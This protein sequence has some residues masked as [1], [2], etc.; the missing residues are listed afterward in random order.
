MEYNITYRQKDKG[1]QFIISAKI[2]NKWK[3]VASKQGFNSKKDAKLYATK[4]LPSIKAKSENETIFSDDYSAIKFDDLFKIFKEHMK[5]YRAQNTIEGYSIAYAKFSALKDMKVCNIKRLHM[6][7]CI[8]TF[9]KDG[10]KSS[11]IETY[12]KKI[13]QTF[14]FYK[15]NYDS[16]YELP[17]IG[18][19]FSKKI[20]NEKKALT[21]SELQTVMSDFK[22]N[23]FQFY[24]FVLL[25]GYC[26]LRRGESLG[27][28]WFD[29]NN[30]TKTLNIDK[31]WKKL[32][33]T[34]WGFADTKNGKHREVP[35][36]DFVI[37]ELDYIR[38]HT[39]T[40]D[41]NNRITIHN[42]VYISQTVNKYLKPYGITIHELRHTYITN[43][44]ANGVDFRTVAELAGDT[45]RMIY[46]TYSH[47]ND[48]MM[49]K[50]KNVIQNIF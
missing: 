37:K 3:Q 42:G 36:S 49:T 34:T 9:I 23:H 14:I 30:S 26:G 43:L 45:L 35:L 22:V 44:V 5:L 50:A 17:T 38:K 39:N 16:S 12:T 33:D 11:S 40:T 10:I 46:D 20:K 18:L 13:K 48:E 28:T 8:D 27:V 1:W 41:I 47:V 31:Q 19:K 7:R 6:Q 2:K 4:V 25:C 29:V 15:D 21:L 24:P 32:S